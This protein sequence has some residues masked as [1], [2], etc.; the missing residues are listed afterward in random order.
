MFARLTLIWVI[1]FAALPVNLHFPPGGLEHGM[2]GTDGL[3][4]AGRAS[5]HYV[6]SG[7]TSHTPEIDYS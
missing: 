4:L 2:M 5:K 3:H 1:C 6:Y 7:S